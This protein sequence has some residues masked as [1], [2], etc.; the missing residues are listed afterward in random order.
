MANI[1]EE[2]TPKKETGAPVKARKRKG[3]DKWKNKKWFHVLAPATFNNTIIAQTPGEE[4]E[5][6]INRTIFV[7]GRELTGNIKK[8][9]LMLLFRIIQVQGLNAY[10]SFDGIEAQ[11]SSIRRLVRR[12]SSKIES[13]DD[14]VCKDN[15]AARIKT[16]ALAAGKI[17]APK[18]TAIRQILKREI[19]ELARQHEYESLL[20][21]LVATDVGSPILAKVKKISPM[22]RVDILKVTKR[23]K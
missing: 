5:S 18:R 17:S 4:A 13:V 2:T 14:V 7:S 9:Q 11:P 21:H 8:S 6:I 20:S 3:V 15:T 10:T 1:I 19:V 12:R 22:K 23:A 16:I